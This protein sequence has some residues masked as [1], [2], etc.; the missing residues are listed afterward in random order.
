MFRHKGLFI[1]TT[2]TVVIGFL[3]LTS[4]AGLYLARY[5]YKLY[6]SSTLN[7]L[8]LNTDS[9]TNLDLL[10][11][12][13]NRLIILYGDSRLHQWKP[14]PILPGTTF[15]NTSK[16]GA[17]S[18][19]LLL[20]LQNSVLRFKP[21]AVVIQAGINDLVAAAATAQSIPL[22]ADITYRNLQEM[23]R[24][25]TESNI[26]TYFLPIIPPRA[27]S[28]ARLPLWDADIPIQVS[29]INLALVQSTRSNLYVLPPPFPT[30]A[31]GY[32]SAEYAKDTLHLTPRAYSILTKNLLDK[33][34]F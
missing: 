7:P 19:Q 33:I 1:T 21:D 30:T 23:A 29:A 6:K 8:G 16:P 31:A 28:I 34:R 11:N 3:L 15:L 5:Y 32:L 13:T 14:A 27:P 2:I 25:T 10:R 4:T 12:H 26:P 17:T 9:E 20:S 22:Q 18:T 24:I